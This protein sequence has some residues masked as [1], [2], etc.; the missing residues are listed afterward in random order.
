MVEE[1]RSAWNPKERG[2]GVDKNKL[3][4]KITAYFDYT[5][6][7]KDQSGGTND[8]RIGMVED[9]N[10]G[11]G[12]TSGPNDRATVV[13]WRTMMEPKT[14]TRRTTSS[15]IAT[16]LKV[17][18]KKTISRGPKSKTGRVSG[19]G[20]GGRRREAVSSQ[21]SIDELFLLGSKGNSLGNSHSQRC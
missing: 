16:K 17:K 3:R 12:G 20:N 8:V 21:P 10:D 6:I 7:F 15:K 9:E 14:S 19:S 5:T 18:M 13:K 11:G 2:G 1:S 4:G